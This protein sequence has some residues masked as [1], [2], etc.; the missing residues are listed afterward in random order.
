MKLVS[1]WA[2]AKEYYKESKEGGRGREEGGRSYRTDLSNGSGVKLRLG[3]T[4]MNKQVLWQV[5]QEPRVFA[6]PGDRQPLQRVHSEHPQEDV[7]GVGAKEGGQR[8]D[9]RA[10]LLE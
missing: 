9:A 7:L 6:D 1:H 2:C 10:D 3:H 5:R 4:V 8:E